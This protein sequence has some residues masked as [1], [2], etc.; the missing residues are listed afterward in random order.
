MVK[1][2]WLGYALLSAAGC[3]LVSCS[4]KP[5]GADPVQK[6]AP[7]QDAGLGDAQPQVDRLASQHGALGQ[8]YDTTSGSFVLVFPADAEIPSPD[9]MTRELHVPIRIASI[10]MTQERYNAIEADAAHLHALHPG[11]TYAIYLDLPTGKARLTSDLPLPVVQP[12]LQKYPHLIELD[13]GS[14]HTDVTDSKPR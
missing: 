2:R 9:Q 4:P 11:S 7:P 13:A 6:T 5:S 10:A 3:M 12:L 1:F 14:I 8:Y